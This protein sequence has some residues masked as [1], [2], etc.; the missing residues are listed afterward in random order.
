MEN[1]RRFEKL[2]WDAYAGAEKFS[3]GSEPFIYEQ[4]L[5]EGRTGVSII[6]DKNGIQISVFNEDFEE[7][8]WLKS[9]ELTACR[10]EGEMRQLVKVIRNFTDAPDIAY[11]LDHP[12]HVPT[13]GFVF[14]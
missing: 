5:N 3:N 8:T 6:A 7:N 4:E 9:I 11:E 10:A 2:D 14:N 13:T 12:S 1:Y